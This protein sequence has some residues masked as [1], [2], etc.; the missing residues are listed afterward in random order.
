MLS[1]RAGC[2]REL[3]RVVAAVDCATST[4]KSFVE[5]FPSEEMVSGGKAVARTEVVLDVDGLVGTTDEDTGLGSDSSTEL[6]DFVSADVGVVVVGVALIEDA[7]DRR[8]SGDEPRPA[9]RAS[10]SS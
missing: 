9:V 5:V 2:P 6:V 7:L 10:S 4:E 1:L 8:D 3:K